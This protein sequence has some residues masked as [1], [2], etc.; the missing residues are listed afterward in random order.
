M[1]IFIYLEFQSVFS[2]IPKLKKLLKI[3]KK[4]ISILF[5]DS[6]KKTKQLSKI[7]E[8]LDAVSKFCDAN[9]DPSQLHLALYDIQLGLTS[10]NVKMSDFNP[11]KSKRFL[12]GQSIR[13][14]YLSE[15]CENSAKVQTEI[16]GILT[17]ARDMSEDSRKLFGFARRVTHERHCEIVT[18]MI[19]ANKIIWTPISANEPISDGLG[20]S[21][22]D[23]EH[24][25]HRVQQD[26]VLFFWKIS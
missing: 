24:I 22:I 25:F 13:R 14:Q 2:K 21:T 6:E 1:L 15:I 23:M 7:F 4:L 9:L 11:I 16:E 26:R 18:E 19:G 12:I 3:P 5:L 10:E 20:Q 8:P 17:R